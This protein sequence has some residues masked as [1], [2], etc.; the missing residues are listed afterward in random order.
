MANTGYTCPWGDASGSITSATFDVGVELP[1]DCSHM[2][3]GCSSLTSLD[4]SGWDT[5]SV[6]NMSS[7]FSGCSSLASL[8]VS[9]WDTS[10]VTRMNGMFFGCS[11]LSSLDVSAWDTSSVTLMGGMFQGCS[12]LVTVDVSAWDTSSVTQTLSMFQGCSSLA[13]LDVSAWD[14]SS[15]E[16]AY[17]M[18]SGCSSLEVIKVGVKYKVGKAFPFPKGNGLWW[19]DTEEEWFTVDEIQSSRS[20]IADTYRSEVQAISFKKIVATVLDGP[21]VYDG[22]AK[23]PRIRVERGSERLTEGIDYSIE[24]LN[25]INAGQGVA[26]IIG[27]GVYHGTIDVLFE[28]EPCPVTVSANSTSKMA[29]EIDP[30]LT[31]TVEGLLGTDEISYEVT[32]E[33]GNAVGAYEI[34]PIG[35]TRQGNYCVTYLSGVLTIKPWQIDQATVSAVPEVTYSGVAQKPKPVVTLDGETLVE[36][37]G[38]EL[39][40]RDN[41]NAGTATVVVSGIGDYAG[42]VEATFSIMPRRATVTADPASKA[43]GQ[44]DPALTATVEGV[45]DGDSVSYELTRQPGEL[46]GTYAVTASGD[47]AQGNYLVTFIGGDL[48]INKAAVADVVVEPIAD[49]VYSGEAIEPELSVSVRG[50]KLE[51]GRDYQ[52]SF[53]DNVDAGQASAVITGT[54]AFEGAVTCRFA[55]APREATVRAMDATKAYG[56]PDPELTATVEGLLEGDELSYTLSRKPG[57]DVGTYAIT[58][59]GDESQGNYR[60]TF[61]PGTLEVTPRAVTVTPDDRSKAYGAPDPELT[62]TVEGLLEGDEVAYT[63]SRESGENAGSYVIAASGDELQGNYRV[64]YGTASFEILGASIAGATIAAIPS[65]QANGQAIEPKPTV[66]LGGKTLV[67]GQDYVLSYRNNVS[68]GTATVIVRGI[69]KYFGEVTATFKIEA[70]S[71]EGAK[72]RLSKLQYKKS[73]VP[74]KP[75]VTVYFEA[76]DGG[77]PVYLVKDVD[78]TVSY[79]NNTAVGTA[80]A[81]IT[82]KGSYEG[83]LEAKYWIASTVDTGTFSNGLTYSY[84]SRVLI[85]GGEGEMTSP[86]PIKGS[87]SRVETVIIQEG[88]TS[89]CD[90]AFSSLRDQNRLYVGSVFLPSSLTYIGADAF[91]GSKLTEVTIPSNVTSIG[92]GAFEW[93]KSLKT[94]VFEEGTTAISPKMFYF[95]EKLESVTFAKSITTIGDEAFE[96]CDHLTSVVLGPNVESIGERAFYGCKALQTAVLEG[97]NRGAIGKEAFEGS[98]LTSLSIGAG[99][100]SIGEGAF[101]G[102][103]TL[104]SVSL[105]NGLLTIEDSAFSGCTGLA[106]VALPTSLKT[107]GDYAFRRC[108]AL[109]GVV[110]PSDLGSIGNYAFENCTSAFGKKLDIPRNVTTIGNYAFDMGA[111]GSSIEK[112]EFLGNAPSVGSSSFRGIAADAIYPAGN[113]TWTGDLK[114]DY[115]GT[116][117]WYM[118]KSNG[119]L[120][121]EPYRSPYETV[122]LTEELN[123]KDFH[124]LGGSGSYISSVSFDMAVAKRSQIC[125]AVRWSAGEYCVHQSLLLVL[126]DNH[127]NSLGKRLISQGETESGETLFVADCP[128]GTAHLEALYMDSHNHQSILMGVKYFIL[129]RLDISSAKVSS[130]GTYPT[131][132]KAVKPSPKVTMTRQQLEDRSYL[133]ISASTVTDTLKA[134]R[135]YTLTYKN[136]VKAGTAS[137]T[138][139]GKGRYTGSKTIKF[140]LADPKPLS[141][142]KINAIGTQWWKGKKLTP[143]PVIKDGNK[144]LKKGTDFTVTYTNNAKVGKATVTI[145]GKGLYKGTVKRTFNIKNISGAWKKSGSRWWYE[146]KDGTYPKSVFYTISGKSYRFDA[147]GYMLTGWQK[148]GSKYY[149]FGSDGV[150]RKNTWAGNYWLK[151]DGTMATNEWVDGG[152]YWV[153]A[154]GAWV[155][156]KTR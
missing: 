73:E 5:S 108:A 87:W 152:K 134:G 25:N 13:S 64:T 110:L 106:S 8:D 115:G 55:I 81:V 26:R 78:Y 82:G 33:P 101:T 17:N 122:E 47:E 12:S 56:A 20:G 141:K 75:D 135:D 52:V 29:G 62:A 44:P 142:T 36:D 45:I 48:T 10:S 129:G 92:D 63:L 123:S 90:N 51:R 24:Y 39:S 31:A 85:I 155:K 32:R 112:I 104:K 70:K 149:F 67:L 74:A 136:N 59:S 61:A 147:S 121:K 95:C 88:V 35:N 133:F 154:N 15:V 131:T 144:T 1:A 49:Q 16:S 80:T 66:A 54:G 128:A 28:I 156:G 132:G 119:A 117:T 126:K 118:R 30:T 69:G 148:V 37:V 19:S 153:G 14:T 130:L 140:K 38:Y 116:L 23:R 137:V 7:M 89:V 4:V 120:E 125:V 9:G 72:V 57:E 103:T 42:S 77:E 150:M 143:V 146:W 76:E 93:S 127:G 6:T 22:N 124:W 53:A 71:L 145:K 2:F 43:I 114:K 18:F 79:R 105:P 41:V 11:Q 60:V 107:I 84:A 94:I 34:K 68:A 46:P 91:Y 40:Y 3:S 109:N 139:K 83:T 138:I 86:P 99:Y 50:M 96:Y 58:A 65:Q 151:A 100:V 113:K 27:S 97:G 21:C 102:I 98:A 111:S